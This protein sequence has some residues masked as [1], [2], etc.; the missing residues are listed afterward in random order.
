MLDEMQ[1][2]LEAIYGVRAPGRVGDFV[3]SKEV[4][5]ELGAP[6]SAASEELLVVESDGGL[7]VALYISPE[8]LARLPRAGAGGL[9]DEFGAGSRTFVDGLLPAFATAAEGVSHFVYLTL[10]ALRER[11]VSLLELEVQAEVDKFAIAL[12]HLW[13]HGERRRSPEL[14]ARLFDRVGYRH[15]LRGDE[16]DRYRHANH[17]ARSYAAFLEARFVLA[18]ALERLLSELRFAYR[19]AG[20]EKLE[21]FAAPRLRSS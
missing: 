3:A 18:G 1:R 20:A 8:V 6:A 9:L 7:E 16:R 10:Q 14:R 19:L 5:E 12:L 2:A 13:K 21:H 11:A 15:D 4:L 17:L